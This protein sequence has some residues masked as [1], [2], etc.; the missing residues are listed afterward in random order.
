MMTSL[1]FSPL[2]LQCTWLRWLSGKFSVPRR[3][4]P[5]YS[6]L[7][8]GPDL[9]VFFIADPAHSF[10]VVSA[11]ERSRCDNSSGH[12]VPDAGHRRQFFLCRRVEVDLAEWILCFAMWPT[13]IGCA[14]LRAGK[15]NGRRS[16]RRSTRSR[17]LGGNEKTKA[18]LILCADA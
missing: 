10:Q 9:R 17:L 13:W 18:R 2:G 4:P 5:S 6:S 14:R 8:I 7:K 3:A 11:S 16:R 12:Y 1:D 15:R